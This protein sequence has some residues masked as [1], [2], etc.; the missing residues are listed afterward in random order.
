[1]VH[2]NLSAHRE[3][4]GLNSRP[5]TFANRAMSGSRSLEHVYSWRC[6]KR[7]LP[8]PSWL[9]RKCRL[10]GWLADEYLDKR[11]RKITFWV[12]YA[13]AHG[14]SIQKKNDPRH[15]YIAAAAETE[16]N[17]PPLKAR[18]IIGNSFWSSGPDAPD[19]M[20][21]G[22]MTRLMST[23]VYIVVVY[24][25]YDDLGTVLLNNSGPINK[26]GSVLD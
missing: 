19:K 14:I 1:L 21:N 15:H 11:K 18:Y 6:Q 13:T 5:C 2:P 26:G 12:S 9:L 25:W 24:L 23:L 8:S 3:G 16:T 4:A 17:R 20:T 10:P 7:H 22:R